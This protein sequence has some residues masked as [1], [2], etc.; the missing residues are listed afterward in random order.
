M[1]DL[2]RR[3]SRRR[4]AP[5]HSHFD[6]ARLAAEPIRHEDLVLL[7][8]V[9]R[10]EDVG[11][12]QRLREVA[13][14][15]EDAQYTLCGLGRP[16]DVYGGVLAAS[17]PPRNPLRGRGQGRAKRTGLEAADLLVCPLGVVA[18]GDDGRDIAASLRVA[19][20]SG[21]GRHVGRGL[22]EA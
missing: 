10:A 4:H 1:R 12:L 6:W 5:G 3:R 13:E 18:L 19:V 16:G 21:H 22:S 15:I 7:L 9:C 2:E 20:R 14:D 17:P 11:P 8:V